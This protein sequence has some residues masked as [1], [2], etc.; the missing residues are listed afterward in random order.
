MLA[1]SITSEEK[2]LLGPLGPLV[3]IWEGE[4][5]ADVAPANDRGTRTSKYRE[6]LTFHPTGR[7]DNHEQILYGLRYSTTAWRVDEPNPYHEES[8]Y[9]M[10][11][12][13]RKL[14]MRAFAIPRGITLL[15]G[16]QAEPDARGFR[17]VAEL[18]SGTWG[19]C[20]NPFLDEEFRTVRYELNVEHIS[21]GVFSYD[22]TTVLRMKGRPQDFAHTDGNTLH[23]VE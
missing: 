9:W 23:R 11:D 4:K 5:G 12:A 16:G 13:A 3:G 7:V 10:W 18:G 17:I 14:V 20:S 6:R 21:D 15:A 22:E 2:A 19:I 8:G 1:M